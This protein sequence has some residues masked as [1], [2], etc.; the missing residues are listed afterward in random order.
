MVCEVVLARVIPGAIGFSALDGAL[1]DSSYER[2]ERTGIHIVLGAD[3]RQVLVPLAP[4]LVT[5]VGVSEHRWLAM[6]DVVRLQPGIGTLA[7]DGER[8]IEL[9]S[10]SLVEVQLCADGPYVVDVPATL[11][12]AAL[13]GHLR[14]QQ[15]E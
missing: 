2:G 1:L 4:G 3:S 8:E 12:G 10:T 9:S 11:E 7:L 14:R 5:W 6:D 15:V 13:A